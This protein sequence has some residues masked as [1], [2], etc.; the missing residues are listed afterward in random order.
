MITSLLNFSRLKV[1][2]LNYYQSHTTKLKFLEDSPSGMTLSIYCY[3]QQNYTKRTKKLESEVDVDLGLGTA[4]LSFTFLKLPFPHVE[5]SR[6]SPNAKDC[7][8]V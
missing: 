4:T 7:C 1:S 8:K 6:I 2:H 5:M 3:L